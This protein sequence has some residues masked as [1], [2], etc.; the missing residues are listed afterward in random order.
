MNLRL[1]RLSNVFM[2]NPVKE[3]ACI[4]LAILRQDSQRLLSSAMSIFFMTVTVCV[5]AS[6]IA[7]TASD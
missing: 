5:I 2:L 3:S 1:E 6:F 4:N 7:I